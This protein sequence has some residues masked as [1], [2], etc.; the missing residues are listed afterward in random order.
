MPAILFLFVGCEF[1]SIH[2]F[3]WLESYIVYP[4]FSFCE[5][6]VGDLYF[7]LIL[8]LIAFSR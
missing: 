2:C 4:G 8:K 1:R 6:R 7:E 3:E 5:N